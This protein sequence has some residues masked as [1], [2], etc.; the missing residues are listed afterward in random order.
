MP[1]IRDRVARLLDEAHDWDQI[2]KDNIAVNKK[3]LALLAKIIPLAAEL[4]SLI[5]DKSGPARDG[6]GGT[7]LGY[8]KPVAKWT[9]DRRA[10][11]LVHTALTAYQS[12]EVAL[13]GYEAFKK[14]QK[15][16]LSKP[17]P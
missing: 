4:E 15:E 14:D 3:A 12:L 17:L 10:Y 13:S 16:R 5:P 9:S 6:L 8:F 2:E 7:Q 1:R 11:E